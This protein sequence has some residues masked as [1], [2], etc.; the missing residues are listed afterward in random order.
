[1]RVSVI[2]MPKG[3]KG[4]Q[5]G[6]SSFLKEENHPKRVERYRKLGLSNRGKPSRNKGKK[7][8]KH[9][10]NWR[11]GITRTQKKEK[12]AGRKKPEQCEICGAMGTICFDHDH[13]TGKFRG[14]ICHRCN[15]VLGFT[16]E[17]V[18]LLNA[19]SEYLKINKSN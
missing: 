4:F 9:S 15:V 3:I 7:T 19:L 6:H 12:I 10:H 1:M 18:D 16:K 5:K 13:K 11:G 8:G 17:N 2:D 14:W